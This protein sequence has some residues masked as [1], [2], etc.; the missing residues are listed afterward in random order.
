MEN[1]TPNPNERYPQPP[2]AMYPHAYEKP[3]HN[4]FEKTPFLAGI[5]SVVPGLGNVY[6]GLYVRGLAF[7]FICIGLFL[8]AILEEAPPL[9][10]F[11]IFFWLFNVIDAYRQATLI[12]Y[13]AA[14]ADLDPT[15]RPEW[16]SS[17]GMILGVALSLVG[18]YGL[19]TK[20]FPRF[21]LS[22][23]FE[24]WW[25][26][27]LIFGPWLIFKTLQERGLGGDKPALQEA[28][29]PAAE[30]AEEEEAA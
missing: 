2:P 16:Q 5:L 17:G 22:E 10:P 23:L 24:Y 21:D 26:A 12:N 1:Q 3:P 8:I 13:G 27:F 4:P 30:E 9:I 20:L 18:A 6:N 7:A 19:V 11:I 25:V 29:T 14:S 15:R 28:G